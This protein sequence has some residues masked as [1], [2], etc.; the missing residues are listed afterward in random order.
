MI[1]LLKQNKFYLIL[2]FIISFYFLSYFV[3]NNALAEVPL[4]GVTYT[5][6]NC[7]VDGLCNPLGENSTIMSVLQKIISYLLMIGAP[8]VG[9]M[10]LYG[11]FL[12]LTAQ[13]NP[14]KVKQGFDTIKW[15]A[16]GYIIVLC[17][18]GIVAIIKEA[19]GVK[20]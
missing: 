13:D 6:P 14:E 4:G 16:I 8:I 19:I 10:V 7:G 9:I 2:A 3:V 1:K 11:G 15:A 5:T 17:A 20:P 12:I 18:W